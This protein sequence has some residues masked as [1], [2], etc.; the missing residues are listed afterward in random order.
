[1]RSS[2]NPVFSSLSQDSARNATHLG[3]GGRAAFQQGQYGQPGYGAQP[4]FA[5]Q[6]TPQFADDT[7]P[8]TIDDVVTKTAMTL[9]LLSVVG[10]IAFFV[11]IKFI[12]YKG[13]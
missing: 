11:F 4:G 9:G 12:L 7:R 5:P 13:N 2:S 6:A 3:G 10:V 8:M 1:M